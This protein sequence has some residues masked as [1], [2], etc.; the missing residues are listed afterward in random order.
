MLA[1]FNEPST[2]HQHILAGVDVHR[3]QTHRRILQRGRRIGSTHCPVMRGLTGKPKT[4]VRWLRTRWKNSRLSRLGSQC[5]IDAF[6]IGHGAIPVGSAYGD[7]I[8]HAL[9]QRA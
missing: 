9:A 2:P 1:Q 5:L 6:A 4:S 7:Y 8:G 3:R